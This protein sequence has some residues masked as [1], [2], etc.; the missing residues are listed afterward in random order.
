MKGEA[1]T[2]RGTKAMKGKIVLHYIYAQ[3]RQVRK[4]LLLICI[5][6]C[7]CLIS[8]CAGT[9]KVPIT[10]IGTAAKPRCFGANAAATCP[11]RY[12]SKKKRGQTA[13]RLGFG[14]T[15]LSPMF[16]VELLNQSLS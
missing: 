2:L 8:R 12:M 10:M 3:T 14:S 11:L 5:N 15:N 13:P 16:V 6:I 1:K 9:D 4:L 7:N